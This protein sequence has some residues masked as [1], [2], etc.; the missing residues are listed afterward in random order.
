MGV[1]QDELAQKLL[2]SR[3]KLVNVE[4]GT[5]ELDIMDLETAFAVL[6]V[7]ISENYWIV[8]LDT[9]E[10]DGYLKYMKTKHL[11]L[12]GGQTL[13][14]GFVGEKQPLCKPPVNFP[15]SILCQYLCK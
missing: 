12:G 13:P 9:Q 1:S 2:I 15:I 7:P 10:L 4:N 6:G 8:H 14:I 5:V 11:L 3:R